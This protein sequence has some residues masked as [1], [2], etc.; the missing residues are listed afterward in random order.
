MSE[1]NKFGTFS[2]VFTPAILTILGVIMYLRLPWIVGQAGLYMS[3][4]IIVVAHIISVT[5][6]LSVASIATDKRVKTGGVYYMISRS[7]GLPIGGTLGLALFIGLSFSVSLYLIGFSESFLSFWG[8]EV[9]KTTIRISGSIALLSVTVI[10]LISTNL[11]LKTQ[12]LIMLA[13]G[14]SLVS[15]FL[16]KST[17]VAETPLLY[18]AVGGASFIVLFGIFFPAV[19]GFTAGVSMS[20]DLKDP[21]RSI[22]LGTV[23]AIIFGFI[24]YIGMAFFFSYRVSSDQLVNNPNVLLDNSLF[25]PLV[26]AGIWGATLSSALGSVLGA[27]RIL[28]AISIDKITPKIFGH[29]YGKEN[30]PRN[31][32]L[33][34]VI[35]AEAGILIGELDVIARV[36]S[37]FFIT[38]YGF[39][40]MSCAIENWA[41]P[42]FRPD[43]RIPKTVSVI[44]AI[45]C[46]VVM[47]QLDLL[48]M[49]GATVLLTSLFFYLKR[50]ELTLESGDTW[51]GVWSSVIREGLSRLNR[52]RG[53]QRNWRPN[54]IL[55]SGGTAARPHLINLGKK[56]VDKRG[57]LSN[58]DLVETPRSKAVIPKAEQSLKAESEQF[59]GVFARRVQCDDIYSAMETITKYYGFSGI[60]PNTVLM[61]WGRNSQKPEKFVQLIQSMSALDYNLMLLNYN[62]EKGF[63]KHQQIDI[64]WRGIGNT[65]AFA[66]SLSRF[67]S[68]SDEWRDAEI[69]FLI[70]NNDT[71]LTEK[72]YENMNQIVIDYRIEATV[73]VINNAV[74]QKPFYEI[75]QRESR[76]ADL[77]INGI[78][79]VSQGEESQ[80][81]TKTNAIIDQL[82]TVLLI[83]ASSFFSDIQIGISEKKEVST[84]LDT[85]EKNY[86]ISLDPIEM[87]NLSGAPANAVQRVFKLVST[88]NINFEKSY[89]RKVFQTAAQVVEDLERLTSITLETV[90]KDF[91]DNERIRNHRMLTRALGDFL[92]Q[93]HRMLEERS[94]EKSAEQKE[95]L[96]DGIKWLLSRSGSIAS[97]IPDKVKAIRPRSVLLWEK[98]DS[99][100]IRMKKT[101]KRIQRWTLRGEVTGSVRFKLL[102]EQYISNRYLSSC[103]SLL[104]R[105]TLSNLQL[106]PEL[107]RSIDHM[108]DS[109]GKIANRLLSDAEHSY[110]TLIFD[111]EQ[112]EKELANIR[113]TFQSRYTENLAIFKAECAE[114]PQKLV[115]DLNRFDSHHDLI[116]TR[117]TKNLRADWTSRINDIPTIWETN[118]SIMLDTT[119]ADLTILLFKNRISTIVRRSVTEILMSI[120]NKLLDDFNRLAAQL[121]KN[122]D[123][124]ASSEAKPAVTIV[125]KDN[126]LL[127]ETWKKLVSEIRNALNRLPERMNTVH[128]DSIQQASEESL[129]L[130]QSVALPF[131]RMMEF[132]FESEFIG[133]LE[134]KIDQ[135]ETVITRSLGVG[136]DIVRLVSLNLEELGNDTGNTDDRVDTTIETI[137]SDALA[138]ISETQSDISELRANLE[139]AIN[140]RLK[141]TFESLN[142]YSLVG[143]TGKLKQQLREKREVKA[144]AFVKNSFGGIY[145]WIKEFSTQLLYRQSIITS[146]RRE[147]KTSTGFSDSVVD[148]LLNMVEAASPNPQVV[149]AL[150]FYYRHLFIGK[151]SISKDFWV[152]RQHELQKAGFAVRRH[153]SGLSGGLAIIGEPGAGKT[154]LSNFIATR[155]F[156]KQKIFTLYP[157]ADGSIDPGLFDSLLMNTFE[158]NEKIDIFLKGV[159]ENSVLILDDIS[160]WWE[161]SIHG[162]AVIERLLGLIQQHSTNCFFI[163]NLNTLTYQFINR[164]KDIDSFFLDVIRCSPFD[165]QSLK[166]IIMLRHRATGQRIVYK[167]SNEDEL[168]EWN[169]ARIFTGYLRNSRGNISMAFR[170]W[171]RSIQQVVKEDLLINQPPGVNPEP[172][173]LLKSG[174]LLLLVQFLLHGNLSRYRLDRMMQADP[175]DL[176]RELEVLKRS[177]LLQE[178]SG[179]IFALNPFIQPYLIDIMKNKGLL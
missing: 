16:G 13:I 67:L 92:F 55:F 113:S 154:A 153:N 51:E 91:L 24:I 165:F 140:D 9:T 60:E 27:P 66:F 79:D 155:Y 147:K 64:W 176:S 149:K 116:S 49:V 126:V 121:K 14:L 174:Q 20:G 148:S 62:E 146:G 157:P 122:I 63:G 133:P 132:F 115:A 94:G 52:R 84:T 164:I 54:I 104:R 1:S 5:T 145:L 101:L 85:E 6:G 31:A 152:G 112:I 168:N 124:S 36:V 8:F 7:L 105:I 170:Q 167:N 162:F 43:F 142:L 10:T 144:V 173:S 117:R 37:M 100:L 156:D 73:H 30:E 166:E 76:D 99:P 177:G 21:K 95:L 139:Q 41:S 107:Q 57:L 28:Q 138:R 98:S 119:V 96:E 34:T 88:V 2:G 114:I 56:L 158:T 72:L 159:P 80:Y 70:I 48:A 39:L 123:E 83:R 141:R 136:Q 109:L 120:Q 108:T 163:I 137:F 59:E 89:L 161:R 90:G 106:Y 87:G 15:I 12:F 23:L 97:G 25:S 150:P 151:P 111:K 29:G 17:G 128:Q 135:S 75:I 93:S 127:D 45:T 19:T 129:L 178:T 69:R 26:V 3:I 110:E 22:P 169:I 179:E 65:A 47:I 143:S 125:F 11:A 61:G 71:A 118:Q 58:F 42:D 81:V 40:N 78:P 38:T 46:L 82:G 131:R 68:S 172:L 50:K 32:L 160:R 171:I 18:P 77:I 175:K 4:G 53:Q 74:E 44:G 33:L 130:F 86:S 134:E 35:I 102:S 103:L